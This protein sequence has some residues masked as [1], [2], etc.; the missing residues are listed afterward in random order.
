MWA[1]GRQCGRDTENV[2]L[3]RAVRDAGGAEK[4][5]SEGQTAFCWRGRPKA[6]VLLKSGRLTVHFRTE[7]RRTPWAECRATD[8]QDCMPAT[9][10]IL[11]GRDI[12]VRAT[13]MAPCTWIELPPTSFVLL[14]HGAASFRR[15]LF[16]QHVRRL[17]TFFAR[18]SS[19]NAISLDQRVADWLLGHA[20]CNEVTAT[21]I[22]IAADLI[23]ARE[24]VS[25]KL[26]DFAAKGWIVQGRG[27]IRIEAPAALSRLARGSFSVAGGKAGAA[28]CRRV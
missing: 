9:A 15:A 16:A 6:F 14:V 5:A 8:G 21:H 13:C 11:S 4:S 28:G 12:S 20:A 10:A 23:T 22:E 26:R 7:T 1:G 19:K 24:V 17:P 27:H 18:L 2:S 25:R 3:E